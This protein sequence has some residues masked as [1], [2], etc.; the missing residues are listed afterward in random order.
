LNRTSENWLNDL[1]RNA[2]LESSAAF[3]GAMN[4]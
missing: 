3:T 4:P 1:A 2:R